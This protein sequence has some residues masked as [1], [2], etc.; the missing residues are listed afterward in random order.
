MVRRRAVRTGAERERERER[1]RR[2]RAA[3]CHRNWMPRTHRARP[4]RCVHAAPL[5]DDDRAARRVA[6]CARDVRH[7][8]LAH[9]F[10]CGR[11]DPGRLIEI[12]AK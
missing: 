7:H 4:L 5:R 3:P 8:R 11:D 2:E 1:G 10:R 12:E 9:A 6:H